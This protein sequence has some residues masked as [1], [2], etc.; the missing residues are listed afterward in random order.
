MYV[1]LAQLAQLPGARELSQ[2][3][4]TEHEALVDYALMDA[5]LRGG[6]RSAYSPD[7]I[8]RADEAAERIVEA[9]GEAD[10]VINGFLAR[11]GYTLPLDPVPS[12]VATWSRQ[13]TRYLLNKDRITDE[14]TDPIAR[15]YRD[16]LK[17]LQLTA[18]GKF[19]L[20][21][22]DPQAGV[23]L[24]TVQIE[25]DERVFSRTASRAFR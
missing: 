3:A 15:D 2:V 21:M 1:T 5:T 20:G 16:A 17:F 12:I 19:S 23:G 14:R 13:I 6:D 11:R 7:D 18:D 4:T 10:G 9:I 22:D 8:A 25:G 24:G